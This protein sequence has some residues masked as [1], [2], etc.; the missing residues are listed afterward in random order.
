VSDFSIQARGLD[1]PDVVRLIAEV[2]AVYVVL[3]GGIDADVTDPGDFTPPDG[4]FLVGLLDGTAVATG[5]WRRHGPEVAEIKRMYVAESARRRG[6]ARL[7]LAELERRAVAA[8]IT[9]MVL[10]TGPRQPEAVA[11]Y[12]QA[13]YRP[14]TTR[15]GRYAEYPHSLFFAKDLDGPE[16][17]SPG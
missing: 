14:S 8:G 10:N 15:F 9:R 17:F 2:Q 12:E 3:Y 5:G 1:D 11:M 16:D 13:G 6:L 7:M 4:L